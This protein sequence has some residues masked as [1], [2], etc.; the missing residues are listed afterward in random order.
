MQ[1]NQ[2]WISIYLPLDKVCKKNNGEEGKR[3]YS[4]GKMLGIFLNF[5]K[6]FYVILKNS[7]YFAQNHIPVNFYSKKEKYSYFIRFAI[8]QQ[9]NIH[10]T[11]I[12][13]KNKSVEYTYSYFQR[14]ITFLCPTGHWIPHISACGKKTRPKITGYFDGILLPS[15]SPFVTRK[16]YQSSIKVTWYYYLF[17]LL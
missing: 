7:Q 9:R 3:I 10:R 16:F 15:P 4:V 8:Y 1:T 2:S 12:R 5:V 13:A 11:C 17:P 14:T 6:V